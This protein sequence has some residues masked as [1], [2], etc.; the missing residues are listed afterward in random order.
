MPETTSLGSLARRSRGL[1]LEGKV[2][3]CRV[4]VTWCRSLSHA[5]HSW[6]PPPRGS[7][8][9]PARPARP[10][11]LSS[12]HLIGSQAP[13]LGLGAERRLPSSPRAVSLATMLNNH[14]GPSCELQAE[15]W[16]GAANWGPEKV[17]EV[18]L[19]PLGPLVPTP[20]SFPFWRLSALH[21][22]LHLP[23]LR[24]I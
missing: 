11:L 15:A 12:P 3:S 16:R 18:D 14:I 7:S 21:L 22:N 19:R 1:F 23:A 9:C 8:F 10:A 17:M 6:R 24:K 5:S 13:L 20:I 2:L 4:V